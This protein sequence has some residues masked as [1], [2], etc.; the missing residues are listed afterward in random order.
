MT[1]AAELYVRATNSRNLKLSDQECDAD[2]LLAA[3][4]ASSDDPRKRMALNIWRMKHRG[5]IAG[6][7][8]VVAHY[9]RRLIKSKR[10]MSAIGAEEVTKRT[11]LWW[12]SNTCEH[13]DGLGHPIIPDTPHL[14]TSVDCIECA[15]T[16][17]TPLNK[18]IPRDKYWAGLWLSD[19]L[20]SM[21]AIVFA[22]MARLL[23]SDPGI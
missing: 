14:D 8:P 9:M 13:C 21:S 19:E 5:Q 1:S 12:M 3:A 23:R 17:V 4:Y 2:V 20:N 11:I 18:V 22:D 16:G 7:E 6:F 15:G 10:G